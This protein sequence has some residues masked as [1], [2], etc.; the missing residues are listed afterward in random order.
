MPPARRNVFAFGLLCLG[1]WLV[2]CDARL[3]WVEIAIAVAL[4][5]NAVG[6]VVGSAIT[7]AYSPGLATGVLLWVPVS[8]ARGVTAFRTSGRVR[9]ESRLGGGRR[10]GAGAAGRLGAEFT[11]VATV[12]DPVR[13][14]LLLLHIQPLPYSSGAW[15]LWRWGTTKAAFAAGTKLTKALFLYTCT[16]AMT[17][18]VAGRCGGADA[19]TRPVHREYGI[20]L[21]LRPSEYRS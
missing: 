16:R 21:R 8:I 7:W 4:A 19:S 14:G 9:P 11:R 3:R 15:G 20:R 5:G 2:T 18:P 10:C 6:H 17:G 13:G 12:A 1:A